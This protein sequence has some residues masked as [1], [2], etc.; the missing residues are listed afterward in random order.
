MILC[1]AI[2]KDKREVNMVDLHFKETGKTKKN[3]KPLF[4]SKKKATMSR[5]QSKDG[6]MS[7]GVHSAW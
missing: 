5:N 2:N 1:A 4:L 7:S 6:S 3:K